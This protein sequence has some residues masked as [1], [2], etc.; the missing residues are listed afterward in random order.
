ML[1]M[2]KF[3]RLSIIAVIAV[4]FVAGASLAHAASPLLNN[5]LPRGGQRGTEMDVVLHGERLADPQEVYLYQPGITVKKLEAVDEKQVKATIAIAADAPLGEHPVRL[6]TASGITHLGTFW[7]GALPVVEEKEP[8]NYPESA[9]KIELNTTVYGVVENEDIDH[10]AV[11]LKKGQRLTAEVEGLRLGVAMFDPY[12][13]ILKEDGSEL[14]VCDDSALLLQDP[15]LS[16]IAPEDGTYLIQ[17]RDSS[18]GGGGT[19]RYR[20]HVGT[21]PRPTMVYPAGGQAGQ[22]L[23]AKFV[24]DV[25]GTIEKTLKLPDQPADE[26]RV[27]IEQD[28]QLAPSANLVRVSPFANVMEVEPNDS[29]KTATPMEGELPRAFNGVIEKEGDSD[30]FKFAAKKDQVLDINVYARRLRSPLDPVLNIFHAADGKQIQGNDD[31]NGPDSYYRFTAPADGEYVLRVKDHLD[32]G[33]EEFVYR[34]EVTP[35]EPKLV[36]TIPLVANNSQERQTIVVPR[37]NRFATLIRATRSDFGGALKL[38]IPN[39][40]AGMTMSE[41]L[42]ADGVDVVPVVFEAA[43]D[44]PTA[45]ALVDVTGAPADGKQ[46]VR[47]EWT[48]TADLVI[49]GNQVAYYQ[50]KVNKLAVAVAEKAPFKLSLVQPK[51]PLVQSGSM[52]LKVVAERREGFKGAINLSFPWSPPGVGAGGATIAEGQNEAVIPLNAS[53]EAQVANWKVCV[54][55]SSDAGGTVWVSTPLAELEIAPPVVTGKIEMAAGERGETIQVLCALDQKTPFE[56]KAK[57]ELLGL[58]PNTSC[59]PKE[60]TSADKQVVFD[61]KTD[62]K[63]PTGQHK[64][65][66]CSLTVKLAGEEIKQTLG[67]GGVLR[68]DTPSPAA[69]AKVAAAPTTAPAKPLSR[70]EKLRQEQAARSAANAQ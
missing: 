23:A 4:A 70:L 17:L 65:L 48:Q 63:S 9:Q 54:L 64:S 61:V 19:S 37:G 51:A 35:V 20:L 28:G 56:G 36:L 46:Q 29:A 60:I 25:K 62:A 5:V 12:L 67:N 58:P 3:F 41:A 8:N 49:F 47:S 33:G 13:A 27:V 52:P 24:G 50:A 10:V 55:G 59:E 68:I 39:L 16:L 2:M 45:G 18:F 44:A 7:V 42:V 1:L 66:L 32:R 22:E 11:V 40:P 15:V 14:A 30:W 6:R 69:A 31:N 43:A 57:I 21:F 34:V 38:S 53:G 26:H